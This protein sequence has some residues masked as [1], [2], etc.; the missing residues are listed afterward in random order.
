MQGEHYRQR[1]RC[2]AMLRRMNQVGSRQAA[3]VSV[4]YHAKPIVRARATYAIDCCG[5]DA[6]LNLFA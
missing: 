4:A 3:D 1:R 2:A 5:L 6:V